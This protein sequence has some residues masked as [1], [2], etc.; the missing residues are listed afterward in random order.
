MK[1]VKIFGLMVLTGLMLIGCNENSEKESDVLVKLE[2]VNPTINQAH[3][4]TLIGKIQNEIANK[5]FKIYSIENAFKE[6]YKSKISDKTTKIL[7]TEKSENRLTRDTDMLLS[8]SVFV[9]NEKNKTE[10]FIFRIACD[11]KN[12]NKFK[13]LKW[14]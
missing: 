9:I 4:D 1:K 13:T 8:T 7:L 5:D 6:P 3:F 12:C 11:D 14:K 10:F 2:N